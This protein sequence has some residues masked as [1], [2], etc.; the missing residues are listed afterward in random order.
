M[1]KIRKKKL[2][3]K[4]DEAGVV[5]AAPPAPQKP[6][7]QQ[8]IKAAAPTTGQVTPETASDIKIP[9]PA[10]DVGGTQMNLGGIMGGVAAGSGA[11]AN[12]LGIEQ[13]KTGQ[14]ISGIG[15]TLS[16]IPGIEQI[17]GPALQAIGALTGGGGSVDETTGEVT[18]SSG[19][20]K[21][22]G[23]GRSKGSLYRKS[24]RIK[25][26]KVSQTLTENL[27]AEYANNPNVEAQP[28]VLAAEGGIMRKPVDALVSKGELIYNP[29]TKQLSKVPG[30]KGKPNRAD[31]V[32]ARLYEGDVVISNS[33]TMM[34][35]NG[36]TPAQNLETMV[37]KK[38][39]ESE[40]TVKAREAIIRKVVNWQEANKTEPQQYAMYDGGGFVTTNN[41]R[42]FEGNKY[43]NQKDKRASRYLTDSFIPLV[44]AYLQDDAAVESAYEDL[45]DLP[46]MKS[47]MI[48]H[49]NDKRKALLEN[50]N[51][52][53]YGNV[54]HYFNKRSPIAPPR[55]SKEVLDK[56]S[57]T[58]EMPTFNKPFTFVKP[59][60]PKTDVTGEGSGNGR[61]SFDWNKFGDRLYEAASILTPLFD[62]EKAD[63]VYYQAPVAKYRP[64][65]INVD[66][67]L[68]AIDESYAM[69]RYNQANINPNTG[70][71]MAYGLQ[72]ATNRAKQMSDVY[73][74][75]TNAQNELIGKNVDT[76]NQWSRDYAGIMNNVYDKAAANR[77]AAR[78]INRQN[79][80]TAL[81]NWGQIRKDNKAR[82]MDELRLQMTEP[83]LQY[84][85]EN[86]DNYLKWKKENGYG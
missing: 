13:G 49:K 45:K 81:S 69:A 29:E 79:V 23:F 4:Y 68:R 1:R 22:F 70:A 27:Q 65:G 63:Q 15:S 46:Q 38:S 16:A 50:I 9:Q 8:L 34:M 32:Y 74:W 14:I 58:G 20:T 54:Q 35:A 73:N 18:E 36:K 43:V 26:T 82:Q 33:P 83:L 12:A 77:A 55:L 85:Y 42:P 51:D 72:A 3:P 59:S 71:G 75:Q 52:G 37:N 31:D 80:A 17:A 44:T 64:T 48:K 24:N 78:N 41:E 53:K 47:A 60:A 76:F 66:P 25:N 86:Y 11:I 10:T 5:K 7:A 67:Q 39:K 6:S 30:S 19:L 56:T 61:K 62:R 40:G 21:I 28:N 2:I 57:P 84:G